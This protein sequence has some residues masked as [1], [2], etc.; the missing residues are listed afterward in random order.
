MN[1]YLPKRI[2]RPLI[3]IIAV[4]FAALFLIG[5]RQIGWGWTWAWAKPNTTCADI[6]QTDDPRRFDCEEAVGGN[7]SAGFIRM[8]NGKSGLA[9][10]YLSMNSDKAAEA[11]KIWLGI[12]LA[13][14]LFVAIW[15][16]AAEGFRQR[17]VRE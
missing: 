5:S 7:W 3:A 1:L 16:W 12:P 8:R 2:R 13:L 9:R 11:W 15:N 10:S 6:Y 17:S 14:I 4:W